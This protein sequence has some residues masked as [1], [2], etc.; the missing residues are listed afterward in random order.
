MHRA[1][2]FLFAILLVLG[3]SLL[4]TR[5]VNRDDRPA[6]T[7]DAD[8][9]GSDKSD[10]VEVGIQPTEAESRE[11]RGL[12]P[13][14]AALLA[15]WETPKLALLLTGEIHGYFEPCGCSENQSGGM[16]RRGDLYRR[17]L[18]RGWPVAGFDLGG[19]V[20][21]TRLQ[22]QFKFETFV[23]AMT[24]LGFR[25]LNLGPEELRLGAD[26]LLSQH[27]AEAPDAVSFLSCNLVFFDAPDLG[28]PL[29]WRIVEVGGVRIGVT[30]VLGTSKKGEILGGGGNRDIRFIPPAEALRPAVSAMRD[31]QPDLLVLL[32][33]SDKDESKQLAEEFPEF[34]LIVTAGGYEDPNG[35]PVSVGPALMVDVGQKGKHTGVVGF[36]PD[37]ADA[38]LKFELVQ[39][40]QQRFGDSDQMIEHMSYYQQRLQNERVAAHL[41]PI[42]H[43]SEATFLGA[44]KCSECHHRTYEF[45]K[46]TGHAGALLSLDPAHRRHGYERLKGV[47]RLFDPECLCCHV[48]GWDPQQVLRFK[49]G[50]INSEFASGSDEE[51]TARLLQGNQ[52]ENCHGPGSRHVDM[53][54][55]DDDAND[56]TAAEL[57]RVT[58]EQANSVTGCYKCHDNDNSPGFDFESYWGKV[59]HYGLDEDL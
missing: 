59:Q 28:T 42:T 34:H 56:S 35:K 9:T 31:E 37:N 17:L 25:V 24:N 32:S 45:W 27:N 23:A 16:S 51:Q 6:E 49:S 36:Y 7:S 48:T 43:G 8:T 10:V 1:G 33:H 5:R 46:T 15:G 57:V 58:L 50:Y 30:G 41:E 20:K 21:R 26:Y 52:C 14:P 18:D 3:F 38:P 29:A 19:S 53:M 4:A 55:D 11:S 22:S 40:D 44:K 12:G 39:L 2:V 54:E 47:P 13:P